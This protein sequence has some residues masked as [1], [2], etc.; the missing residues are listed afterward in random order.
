MKATTRFGPL[1]FTVLASK[2]EGKSER[3]SYAGGSSRQTQTL[4]D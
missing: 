3:A 4:N 2:Q 1:D